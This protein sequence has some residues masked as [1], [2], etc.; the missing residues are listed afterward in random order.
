V[1]A[2][3]RSNSCCPSLHPPRAV[4]VRV[5]RRHVC[6]AFSV[7][8]QPFSVG[9]RASS[10]SPLPSVRCRYA[11]FRFYRFHAVRPAWHVV[12]LGRNSAA[13]V[14]RSESCFV[15]L[16]VKPSPSRKTQKNAGSFQKT[17]EAQKQ[18]SLLSSPC[19]FVKHLLFYYHHLWSCNGYTNRTGNVQNITIIGRLE[20]NFQP[21]VPRVG[22]GT[23]PFPKNSLSKTL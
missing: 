8:S 6:V 2:S 16:T 7:F 22:T 3:G 18:V 12:F 10:C 13:A 11:F 14:W 9:S 1:R 5:H 15:I 19:V 21:V 20:C 23:V 17:L 4:V